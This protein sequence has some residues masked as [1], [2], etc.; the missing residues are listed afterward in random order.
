[1]VL[2]CQAKRDGSPQFHLWPEAP[3]QP[4]A[5]TFKGSRTRQS[6]PSGS[7]ISEL[8]TTFCKAPDI[9]IRARKRPPFSLQ[10][11]H[12][13]AVST[14]IT[15]TCS[16]AT[17][18]TDSTRHEDFTE[19]GRID[20]AA[21]GQ[22][23][24]ILELLRL[25]QAPAAPGAFPKMTSKLLYPLQSIAF[26]PS[27]PVLHLEGDKKVDQMTAHS[28]NKLTAQGVKSAAPGKYSDGGGLWLHQRD[29]GKGQWVLRVT[30]HGRRREMG[31]GSTQDVTLKNARELAG[32]WRNLAPYN[33]MTTAE[34]RAR[35]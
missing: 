29:G 14:P 25:Y 16:G 18:G 20:G 23:S 3:R 35:R 10:C 27:H 5:T 17:N 15:G 31:L 7:N 13:A 21:R 24:T 30:V 33:R 8:E 12:P 1:M 4:A 26:N 9:A 32:K 34:L 22:R 2:P 19:I 11:R 28:L 6:P